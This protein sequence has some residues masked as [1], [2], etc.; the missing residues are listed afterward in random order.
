ML[1]LVL[2]SLLRTSDCI[3]SHDRNLRPPFRV[4]SVESVGDDMRERETMIVVVIDVVVV[5]HFM[6]RCFEHVPIGRSTPLYFRSIRLNCSDNRRC[7]TVRGKS[8][9]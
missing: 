3:L 8:L 4:V 6:K 9:R 7:P 2:P 1:S 5:S